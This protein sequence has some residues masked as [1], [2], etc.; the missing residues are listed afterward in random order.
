MR[1]HS[2][3]ITGDIL[4]GKC[5]CGDQLQVAMHLMA[6]NGGGILVYLAQ[7]GRDIGLMNKMR[8]YALQDAA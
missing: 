6:E 5:D 3:C 4:G 2:Q 8:A 7:E 1:L